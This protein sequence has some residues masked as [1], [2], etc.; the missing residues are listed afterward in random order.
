MDSPVEP[1]LDN[2]VQPS[3]EEIMKYRNIA[4]SFINSCKKDLVS[5]FLQHS[6]DAPDEDRIGVLSIN[7]TDNNTTGGVNVSYIPVRILEEPLQMTIL[8]KISEN[9]RNIIYLLI[10]TPVE[11]QV[12]EVDIRSLM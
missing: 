11:M 12:L 2:Q 4:I 1:V 9:N 7:I 6:R 8:E 10:F 5:I 3:Q